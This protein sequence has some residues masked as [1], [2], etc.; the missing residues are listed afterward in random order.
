MD[1]IN[2]RDDAENLSEKITQTDIERSEVSIRRLMRN[3]QSEKAANS[4][5]EQSKV[6]DESYGLE[7]VTIKNRFDNPSQVIDYYDTRMD[8]IGQTSY[9]EKFIKYLGQQKID[10]RD[11][12]ENSRG[13]DLLTRI[14]YLGQEAGIDSSASL[15]T[16]VH[17]I[18]ELKTL[19]DHPDD[20]VS[21]VRMT[22]QSIS[23]TENGERHHVELDTVIQRGEIHHIRDNKPI[24]L[25]E[26]VD[27]NPDGRKWDAWMKSNFGDDYQHQI[28]TGSLNPFA[29]NTLKSDAPLDKSVH[30]SLQDFM[31][32]KVEKYKSDFEVYKEAYVKANQLQPDQVKINVRPYFVFR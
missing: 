25:K 7:N 16:L 4:Q 8:Q 2:P 12:V 32:K 5:T 11:L 29:D 3:P 20:I 19:H 14:A 24:N 26:F 15:G 13:S 22:E 17:R 21:E 27:K 31:S 9:G 1:K 30:D 10:L 6:T 18:S 23:F 28:Q